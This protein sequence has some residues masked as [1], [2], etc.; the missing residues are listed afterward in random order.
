MTWHVSPEEWLLDFTSVPRGRVRAGDSLD[1]IDDRLRSMLTAL[2]GPMVLPAITGR[3]RPPV[4]PAREPSQPVPEARPA[5]SSGPRA[6]SEPAPQRSVLDVE[7]V[8]LLKTPTDD[9]PPPRAAA[10]A[11]APT[12]ADAMVIPSLTRPDFEIDDD[13]EAEALDRISPEQSSPQMGI[14]DDDAD[15]LMSAMA[16]GSHFVASPPADDE[17]ED[18]LDPDAVEFAENS[19]LISMPAMPIDDPEDSLEA[20]V[21]AEKPA[22]PAERSAEKLA[23]KP[24]EKP[25]EKAPP[26][27]ADKPPPPVEK[28]P[29]PPPVAERAPTPAE[30][31]AE[32]P[33][34]PPPPA[35]AKTTIP[36]P[37]GKAPPPV[38]APPP[39]PITP[40]PAAP[41]ASSAAGA[42]KRGWFDEA[43]GDHYASIQPIDSD[44]SAELD[45]VF[46][47]KSAELGAGQT[48]LDVA[49]GDGRHCFALA[50]LGLMVTGLDCSLSQ[51]VRASQRNESTEA[52]VTLLHG[53]MRAL[54]RDRTYDVVTCLGSS[55]GYFDGDEQNRQVLQEMVEVLRPGG[56]LVLQVFNR[57][58][59]VAVMPC[60][61]WWQGRGCL[62]LDVADMNYFTNRIRI[63]RTVVFEDGRQFEHHMYF[64]A[65][66]LHELGKI[67]TAS[68]MR[69]L[70][71][72]GSRESRG[73]F[74]GATSAEIWLVAQRRE[75]G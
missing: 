4:P 34:P 19:G 42:R 15:D 28:A 44:Q 22:P 43:F 29:P 51:L 10:P 17:P 11:P 23:E 68:G 75:D 53:D 9:E 57:D 38:K 3:P 5:A 58:Y 35:G 39:D 2:P 46:I 45:A 32:K 20:P 12:P 41:A 37:P 48:V 8:P 21:V 18:E 65:Y 59:L 33:A 54:P 50:N 49:C 16:A 64:R 56:K 70:E 62:V 30:K 47:R 7:L 24:A 14:P 61:S 13:D 67:L 73:R 40:L 6:A 36:P 1:A 60:R 27:V 31:P 74:Y 63:H 69:V 25:A 26:P 55:I 66:S 71:V 52:G 72:S